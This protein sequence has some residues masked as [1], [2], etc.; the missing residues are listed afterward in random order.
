MRSNAGIGRKKSCWYGGTGTASGAG[1]VGPSSAPTQQLQPHPQPA[2]GSIDTLLLTGTVTAKVWAT[3]SSRLKAMA[4]SVF[5][6]AKV[7][8]LAEASASFLRY[9]AGSLSNFF[10]QLLQ[11]SLISWPSWTNA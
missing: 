10:L 4:A 6:D 3:M 2:A 8:F 1:A 5:T 11:Q 7:Y 9:L